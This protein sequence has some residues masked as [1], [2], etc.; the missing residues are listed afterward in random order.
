MQTNRYLAFGLRGMCVPT[1]YSLVHSTQ[2]I[3]GGVYQS[4]V[5]N[6]T[7]C[8]LSSFFSCQNPTQEVPLKRAFNLSFSYVPDTVSLIRRQEKL[9]SALVELFGHAQLLVPLF[10]R[11]G[12]LEVARTSTVFS[13]TPR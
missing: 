4:I 9:V 6:A 10:V 3:T 2:P 1:S 13:C 8:S 11:F 12:A 7:K 5:Q